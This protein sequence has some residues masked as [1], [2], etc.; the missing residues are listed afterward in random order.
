MIGK[1]TPL[2]PSATG[3]EWTKPKDVAPNPVERGGMDLGEMS[4]KINE[5]KLKRHREAVQWD[6]VGADSQKVIEI[7]LYMLEDLIEHQNQDDSVGKSIQPERKAWHQA[8]P[9]AFL[10]KRFMQ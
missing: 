9:T 2:P 10:P 7:A 4:L 1:Y 6:S 3:T 8:Y 5:R